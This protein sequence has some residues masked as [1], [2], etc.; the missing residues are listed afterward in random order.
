MKRSRI[1]APNSNSDITPMS[2]R[3]TSSDYHVYLASRE[4]ALL[5]NAVKE[6]SG[7]ICERC[8]LAPH[9][10]THHLTYERLGKESLEDLQGVCSSCHEFLS[11]KSNFDPCKLVPVGDGSSLE[12]FTR[13]AATLE[14]R[15]DAFVQFN[16]YIQS[17]IQIAA[18]EIAVQL[19]QLKL[20]T[21]KRI[22]WAQN[23]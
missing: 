10:Q 2:P 9:Q 6:R 20:E 23:Q 14:L 7:G 17:V 4:W 8:G 13:Y 15:P 1:A 21:N 11:A 16:T 18:P 3:K 5:K 12:R 19:A 22:Y